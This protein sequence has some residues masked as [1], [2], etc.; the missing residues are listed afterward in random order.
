VSGRAVY[1]HAA[2]LRWLLGLLS[3]A[4]SHIGQQTGSTPGLCVGAPLQMQAGVAAGAPCCT[5]PMAAAWRQWR[6]RRP[7]R[8]SR[9]LCTHVGHLGMSCRPAQGAP[10]YALYRDGP[11]HSQAGDSNGHVCMCVCVKHSPLRVNCI[12]IIHETRHREQSVHM[13]V[14][15]CAA[16][17]HHCCP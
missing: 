4:A 5:A 11:S 16:A 13:C 10:L 8:H 14:L 17:R 2:R 3:P 6:P 7:Q 9:T 15:C 1:G 12:I